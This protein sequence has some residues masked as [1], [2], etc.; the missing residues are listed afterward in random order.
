MSGIRR[1][2]PGLALLVVCGLFARWL[3]EFVPL[4]SPLV[5]VIGVS[6][7]IA[8]AVGI[9][10]SAEPGVDT[11]GRWL[12]A[13]IVLMGASVGL[14][15]LIEAGGP[16]L[17]VVVTA[18]C[19][20]I[21][22]V[23][24][25]ARF[26]LPVPEKLGSL[27]AAGSSICGVSAVAAVAASIDPDRRQVAYAA[28]TIL[29]FDAVTLVVYP[30]VGRTLGLSD[31]VFGVWAG[32]TMFSTG[33]VTAAG[34]AYSQPAG[35]WAVIVK[36]ARNALIGAVAVGY[37][38]YYSR[39]GG[40]EAFTGM[41]LLRIWRTVPTFIVGFLALVVLA[42]L[43]AFSSAQIAAM[44]RVSSWLFLVA[45]AGLGFRID[46]REFFDVGMR[47]AA[48]VLAGLFVVSTSVLLVLR[49]VF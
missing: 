10:E 29:L 41:R 24:V 26:L 3:A 31:L 28:G 6:A 9:P 19:V 27:L 47:P 17:L 40:S 49:A 35:E 15:R 33:P 4:G 48:V 37:A 11:H 12:E 38:T 25:L 21:V 23:E 44:D 14:E 2:V 46:V 7:L 20:S 1:L 34:F 22:S 45:F 39:D 36:L 16:V 13:G 42:T 32:A 30:I 5:V 43:G 18:V 8:N